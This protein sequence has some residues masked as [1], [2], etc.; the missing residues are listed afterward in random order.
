MT[1]QK[2][3]TSIRSLDKTSFPV[4]I[5]GK[6]SRAERLTGEDR[7]LDTGHVGANKGRKPSRK[8]YNKM[9]RQPVHLLILLDDSLNFRTPQAENFFLSNK[10][11]IHSTKN[12]SILLKTQLYLKQNRFSCF[13]KYNTS[14]YKK[15]IYIKKLKKTE[16]QYN[17]IKDNSIS[18]GDSS[19]LFI[20]LNFFK[21][22]TVNM[23]YFCNKKF[24]VD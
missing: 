10:K 17:R 1:L 23:N 5:A 3:N 4:S 19:M 2:I 22:S 9:F 11:N 14:F 24:I 15:Q 16:R 6:A 7:G 8:E 13:Q 21:F 12:M 20:V 18:L